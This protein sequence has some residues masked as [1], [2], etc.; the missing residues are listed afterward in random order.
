[1]T[2]GSSDSTFDVQRSARIEHRTIHA[3][4][5]FHLDPLWLWDKSDG[6]ERFR[7]TV[8][9]A[10]D[11]M[12]RNADLTVAASSAALYAYLLRVD[13]GL[14]ERLT[15]MVRAER[16]E[17]V[18]GMWVETD[19]HVPGGEG[20]A[21]QLLL[22]QEFFARHFGRT[23]RVAWSPDSFGRYAQLPR[24]L[25]EADL[26]F[27]AFKRPE[28][29]MKRLPELFYWA[30][31]DGS[32]ILTCHLHEYM[33]FASSLPRRVRDVA[34]D[35][36]E[37]YRHGLLLFGVGN[38]GGGPTQANIDELHRLQGDPSLPPIVFDTPTHFFQAVRDSGVPIPTVLDH[39]DY[40][41]GGGYA[42][43][44]SLKAAYRQTEH[45]LLEAEIAASIASYPAR[46][47]RRGWE[48]LA[49][50]QFHD[51]AAGTCI[52]EV[53]PAVLDELAEARSIAREV[54]LESL[55]AL[56]NSIDIPFVDGT[57][58]FVVFNGTGRPR[59]AFV[60]LNVQLSDPPPYHGDPTETHILIGPD[61]AEIPMQ[62]VRARAAP[63]ARVGFIAELPALGYVTYRL[64]LRQTSPAA[65]LADLSGQ[66]RVLENDALRLVLDN[67]TGAIAEL[68]DRQRSLPVFN[69]MGAMP[70]MV[71]DPGSAWGPGRFET[72]RPELRFRPVVFTR[73]QHGPLLSALQVRS[74]LERGGVPTG[75]T[76][77]Q[78][79]RV[80]RDLPWIDVRVRLSWHE[81]GTALKLAF[82]VSIQNYPEATV[83]I[84]HGTTTYP[85][86]G[87]EVP[88][89]PGRTFPVRARTRMTGS[90]G[91]TA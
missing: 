88:G 38:H 85:M 56:S 10:L 4:G 3:A 1:V 71:V 54:M 80:Y 67:E 9:A 87:A 21:R 14:F 74:V 7:S 29:S 40:F 46:R 76:L 27:F 45:L 20:Y 66:E 13:P 55:H 91:S 63:A 24:L 75:S 33:T 79:F 81:H 28:R 41:V 52:P 72:P 36:R 30:A 25:V 65:S 26:E 31:E 2:H 34:R 22:G 18:G 35:L 37:P 86:N 57:Q 82:P 83:E 39:L 11:L 12:E 70:N 60:T 51:T 64:C 32:Q 42:T 47:L 48:Q 78:E 23:A 73:T 62:L 16:W 61:S 69:G 84:P 89:W 50:N 19:E 68:W 8:R 17:P 49:F 15:E 77:V 43:N 90:A 58:P 53:Y 59:R 44:A 5:H 6:L